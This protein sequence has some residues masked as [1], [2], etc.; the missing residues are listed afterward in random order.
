MPTAKQK[1]FDNSCS[2][3]SHPCLTC[4][5]IGK[6]E[7]RQNFTRFTSDDRH[8]TIGGQKN[9]EVILHYTECVTDLD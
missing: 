8:V 1:S 5:L 3:F 6:L 9:K 2:I 4:L 7:C